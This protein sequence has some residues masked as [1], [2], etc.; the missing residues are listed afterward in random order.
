MRRVVEHEA[1]HRVLVSLVVAGIVAGISFPFL[2]PAM[3]AIAAWDA[4]ALASLIL[5]WAG[6]FF[7]DAKTRVRE[8]HLQDS[9]RTAICGCVVLAAV[10]GFVGAGF[11]LG[12]AKA[13]AGSEAA[14]HAAFG[15][16]TV[17]SSWLLVHT[18]LGLHYAHVYYC[19]CESDAASPAGHGLIFPEEKAPDFID[20]AYLSFV[21]GMT[22][23]VSDVQVTSR[24]IRRVVLLHALL[25]FGFN[26]FILAF[27]INLAAGLL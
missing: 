20:F 19:P 14:W 8:A 1:H 11:L 23:Q 16:L 18:M 7:T 25:S 21:V 2:R 22:F 3:I 27:T 24:R 13:L 15:V 26:T 17:V 5:A 9:S 12:S 4:F 6:M 10:A